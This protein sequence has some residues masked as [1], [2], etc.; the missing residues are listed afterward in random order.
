M[1]RIVILVLLAQAAAAHAQS[2]AEIDALKKDVAEALAASD[3]A[4]ELATRIA[5]LEQRF[6]DLEQQN[7]EDLALELDHIRRD[8]Q[9]LRERQNEI[10]GH[11][12]DGMY[13][14][15]GATSGDGRGE[16]QGRFEIASADGSATLSPVGFLQARWQGQWTESDFAGNEFAIKRVRTGVKGKLGGERVK[17]NFLS[18]LSKS[19]TILNAYVDYR[20]REGVLLRAQV[21][22][23]ASSNPRQ[24]TPIRTL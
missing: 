1:T 8:I 10:R 12:A 2:G 24:S 20:A 17:Y 5:K 14:H 11:I 23:P 22:K 21:K 18:E 7:D 15:H 13:P 3:R 9:T 19:P 6:S 16:S 4:Q